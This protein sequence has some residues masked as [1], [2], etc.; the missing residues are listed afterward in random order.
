MP[1]FKIDMSYFEKLILKFEDPAIKQQFNQ[2]PQE[3]AIAAIIGQAIADNFAK[4]GPGW[5]PLKAST[6]RMSLSKK[7]QKSIANMS[8]AELLAHEKKARKDSDSPPYRKILRRTGLLMKT[9]TTPNFSG[10]NKKSQGG[11]IYKVEGNN[12]I[13]GTDLSYAA[14]HNKGDPKKKIP[15]REFLIIRDEWKN[16]L[17]NYVMKRFAAVISKIIFKEI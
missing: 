8:D 3:K 9:A 10:S 13:W 17:Q 4:E 16:K 15:K 6:I 1:S 7:M 14:I 11:N 2:I 12:I 5:T